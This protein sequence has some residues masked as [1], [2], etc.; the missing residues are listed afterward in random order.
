MAQ[1][2]AVRTP[3]ARFA[4]LP[5]FPW[6]PHYRDDLPGYEGLRM[7]RIDEG[8]EDA[9]QV[10]LCLHGQPSWSFLYRHMIPV[11]LETGARVVAPDLFGFGR[12]DKPVEDAVYTFTFHRQSLVALIEALDLT[13][14]TLVVQDWGGLLG[15]TIPPDMA[16]R[17]DRFLV[18]NTVLGLGGGSTEGFDAW[19][20]FHGDQPDYDM[21]AL[22]QKYVPGMSDAVAAAYAAP[23]PDARYRA[24]ARRFPF[25]VMTRPDMEGVDLSRR[26]AAWWSNDWRGDSFMAIGE[27]DTLIPPW[28]MK[29]M[30]EILAI[31]RDPLLL[32]N[33]GHFVQETHGAE[34][35]RAALAAWG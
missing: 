21:A 4:D 30:H 31:R 16:G 20:Q 35:A 26:A 29:R 24:G 9:G 8:P 34:V 11:F 2:D 18:M 5:D 12:S 13:R 19:R 10:F 27:R 14:I 28:L 33:A 32:P 23:F 22:F 15:L 25:L 1:I 3:D 7:A 6:Q 17:F